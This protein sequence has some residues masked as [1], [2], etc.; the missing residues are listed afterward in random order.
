V[1]SVFCRGLPCATSQDPFSRR[2]FREILNRGF[3]PSCVSPP[4]AKGSS[5]T[6]DGAEFK[7]YLAHDGNR[8]STLAKML[9][10]WV[11]A[12]DLRTLWLCDGRN[13]SQREAV[14]ATQ[15]LGYSKE[16]KH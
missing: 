15:M 16:L 3:D 9:F 8:K 11:F 12:P 4:S 14:L 7:P 2:N 6:L 5:S 10:L 13:K 1:V